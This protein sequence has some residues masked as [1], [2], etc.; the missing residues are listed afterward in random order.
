MLFLLHVV[1]D[2]VLDSCEVV[3]VQRRPTVLPR[4]GAFACGTEASPWVMKVPAGQRI[5]ITLFEF[6]AVAA[7]SVASVSAVGAGPSQ[8]PP[9]FVSAVAASGELWVERQA[10]KPCRS[11]GRLW[12]QTAPPSSLP[13]SG[14]ATIPLDIC[15]GSMT[16][17]ESHIH[18]TLTS[19]VDVVLTGQSRHGYLLVF[20]GRSSKHILPRYHGTGIGA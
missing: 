19:S 14:S 9:P 4:I 10:T 16:N 18:T 20:S 11:Y 3:I 6:S 17:R 7:A 13:S 15:A 5:N 8:R 1:A 2:A 12:E